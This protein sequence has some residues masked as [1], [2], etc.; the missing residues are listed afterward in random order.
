MTA[1]PN[2][3]ILTT[4]SMTGSSQTR[5]LFA[6][7]HETLRFDDA[8]QEQGL[9]GLMHIMDAAVRFN[10]PKLL[11]CCEYTIAVDLRQEY[12]PISLRLRD[13]P[14]SSLLRIAEGLQAA[15]QRSASSKHMPGPKEFLKMAQRSNEQ[16]KV[17]VK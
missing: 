3:Q 4:H 14:V 16:P 13:L 12:S 11:A 8:A 15:Y 6:A 10:M 7:P 1:Y 9:K 17:S 5:P 2:A